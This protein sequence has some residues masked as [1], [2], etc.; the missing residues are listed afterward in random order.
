MR[1][2]IVL[3]TTLVLLGRSVI[4]SFTVKMCY[5]KYWAFYEGALLP[6]HLFCEISSGPHVYLTKFKLVWGYST[7]NSKR[8]NS[9]SDY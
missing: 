8:E 9:L 4:T 6:L 1:I 5:I 2:R 3:L 7:L